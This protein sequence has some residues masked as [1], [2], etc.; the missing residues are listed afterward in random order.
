MRARRAA[1][2][3]AAALVL[4]LAAVPQMIRIA[5]IPPPPTEIRWDDGGDDLNRN[6]PPVPMPEANTNHN[7]KEPV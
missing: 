4:A 1:G 7:P 2:A 6:P 3:I 5:H